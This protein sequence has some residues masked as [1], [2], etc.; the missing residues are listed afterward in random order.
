MII[1]VDEKK[2]I[3]ELFSGWVS[4]E[5]A[6]DWSDDDR[7][8]QIRCAITAYAHHVQNLLADIYGVDQEEGEE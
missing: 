2:L 3:T 4:M 7:K 5:N 8:A 6:I 1:T